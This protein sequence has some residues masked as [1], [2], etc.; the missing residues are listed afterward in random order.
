[1]DSDERRRGAQGDWSDMTDTVELKYI[2]IRLGEVEFRLTVEDARE[3]RHILADLFDANP[4]PIFV[5]Y[6][7]YPVYP[8]RGWVTTTS[9]T[10]IYTI[11][12]NAV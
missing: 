3:L 6:P 4:S 7:V 1:M 5:P 2:V 10:G 9:D 12:A 8:Y 11:I